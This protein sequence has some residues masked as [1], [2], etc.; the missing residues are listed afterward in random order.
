M[1]CPGEE[2]RR[3]L[4]QVVADDEVPDAADRDAERQAR[5]DRVGHL[6][7][8]VAAAPDARHVDE[9]GAG[10]PAQQRDA[11]VPHLERVHE[12]I[13]LGVVRDHVEEACPDDGADQRPER[14]RVHFLG[15]DAALGTDLPQQP[16][17]DHEP[18]GDEEAVRGQ[19]ER[20]AETDPV[21]NG[22]ADRGEDG[23]HRA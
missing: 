6:E 12:R 13:E 7:E 10:D 14:D 15:R 5:R 22:P 18:D 23:N 17:A 2:P 8:G 3:G 19:R 1:V 9:R 20:V 21:E 4:A 16:G 11:A